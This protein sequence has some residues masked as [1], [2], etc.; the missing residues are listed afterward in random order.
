MQVKTLGYLMT[1]L[2]LFTLGA[3]AQAAPKSAPKAAIVKVTAPQDVVV[4]KLGSA[5]QEEYTGGN[6]ANRTTTYLTG[7]TAQKPAARKS[8]PKPQG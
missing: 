3:T 7:E 1:A 4:V 6:S 8:A 5:M 2:T